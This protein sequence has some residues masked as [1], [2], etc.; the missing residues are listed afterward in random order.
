MMKRLFTVLALA[1]CVTLCLPVQAL[2]GCYG[3]KVVVV[4]KVV[5]KKFVAVAVPFLVQVP[6]YSA[7]YAQPVYPP[8]APAPV[9][10][11]PAPAPAPLPPAPPA[12][13]GGDPVLGALRAELARVRAE[14][15][16]CKAKLAGQAAPK[17]PAPAGALAPLKAEDLGAIQDE[18]LTNKMPKGK[19]AL[20]AEEKLAIAQWVSSGQPAPAATVKILAG[21]CAACHTAGKLAKGTDL[22]IFAK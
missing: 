4:K 22:A 12:D 11:P 21:R 14:L 7:G 1:A 8:P 17:A 19:P 3:R 16:E 9:P 6:A 13:G 2:A 5:R 10:Q 20:P 18:V 15:A